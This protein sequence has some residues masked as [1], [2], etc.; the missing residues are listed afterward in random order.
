ML[1]TDGPISLMGP[2]LMSESRGKP[3]YNINVASLKVL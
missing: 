1:Q 2:K 3:M